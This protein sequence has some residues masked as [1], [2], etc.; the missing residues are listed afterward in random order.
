VV[1]AYPRM[2]MV[3]PRRRAVDRSD[4]GPLARILRRL[5]A[6][7]GLRQTD[8][9]TLAGLDQPYYSSLETGSIQRPADERLAALDRAFDLEPGTI[10]GWLDGPGQ[11]PGVREGGTIYDVGLIGVGRVPG[12][13]QSWRLG[14]RV[15]RCVP[16]WPVKM[17]THPVRCHSRDGRRRRGAEFPRLSHTWC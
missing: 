14:H 12:Q 13:R 5:R 6:E 11:P 15:S 7:R 8:I 2:E 17:P 3:V 16:G 10:K 9:A 4:I 1:L